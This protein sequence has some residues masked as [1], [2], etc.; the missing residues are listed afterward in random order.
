LEQQGWPTPSSPQR[1]EPT[2]VLA[3]S[4]SF[5]AG[6]PVTCEHV[7]LRI[8]DLELE[9]DEVDDLIGEADDL[10]DEVCP[11]PNTRAYAESSGRPPIANCI[12]SS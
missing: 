10:I 12:E 8:E 1:L 7:E 3:R 6:S 4:P 9:R 5:V 11:D 2:E